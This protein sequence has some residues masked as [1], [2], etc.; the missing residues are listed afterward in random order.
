MPVRVVAGAALAE[1]DRPARAEPLAKRLLVAL[2][3]QPGIAHLHVAQQPLLGDQQQ[4]AAVGLDAAAFEHDR[5]AVCR[6][7]SARRAA[8][9]AMSAIA[10]P[11]C[12]SSAP[13]GVLR[14]GVERP[15][16]QRDRARRRRPR[17]SA[18]CRA[19]RCDRWAPGA[20]GRGRR[21]RAWLSRIA[22]RV[23]VDRL[24]VA[25]D[26]DRLEVGEHA[27]D[28]AVDPGNR[29]E[30]A[31]PV[32]LVVRPRDPGRAVRLPLG[33]HPPERACECRRH[34]R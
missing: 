1:P 12:A 27:R 15:V 28:L 18:R 5:R 17:R 4:P 31:R 32:R 33:R 9:G 2:A 23:L 7:A 25:E 14:P 34:P 29:R 10:R 22:P 21:A 6:D 3:R 16:E 24:G 13:V 8:A 11:T 19:A 26:L 20:A 30:L